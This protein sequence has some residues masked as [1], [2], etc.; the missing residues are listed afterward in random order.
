MAVP[1]NGEPESQPL[2]WVQPGAPLAYVERLAQQDAWPPAHATRSYDGP[3]ATS[4]L[5]IAASQNDLGDRPLAGTDVLH[6]ASIQLLDE[7]GNVVVNPDNG[8]TYRLRCTVVNRGV[9]AAYGGL[10]DFYVAQ[11][12]DLDNAART[13]RALLPALGHTGFVAGPG[14]TVTIE[15]PNTWTPQTGEEATNSILVH[16]HDPFLDPLVHRFDARA[17]RHVGRLDHIPDFAGGWQGT[18]TFF[19][20]TLQ[21]RLVITQH[22]FDVTVAFYEQDGADLPVN[23]QITATGQIVAARI[24]LRTSDPHPKFRQLGWSSQWEITLPDPD[25]LHVDQFRG[26]PLGPRPGPP[27]QHLESTLSRI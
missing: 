1:P 2:G 4:Y 20:A 15:C 9:V 16:A 13:A 5:V 22:G 23:P 21:E 7:A 12:A 19:G 10:A 3:T 6:S 11:P 24:S 17:D 18:K 26:P 8:I 27:P 14:E 25:T